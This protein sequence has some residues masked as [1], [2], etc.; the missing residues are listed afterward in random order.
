MDSRVTANCGPSIASPAERLSN[1]VVIALPSLHRPNRP[2][3]A[4]TDYIALLVEEDVVV[5]HEQPLALDELVE[6]AGLQGDDVIGP[7]RNVVAPGLSRIDG[8][9]RAHPV[10]HRRAG[11]HQEDMDRGWRD[12]PA[13]A[14]GPGIGLVEID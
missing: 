7:R 8:S 13:I 14:G 12:Q 6:R 4:G 1:V 11:E 9:R 2:A 5:H 10:I 3:A